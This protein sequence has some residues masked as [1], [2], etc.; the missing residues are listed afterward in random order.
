M[1]SYRRINLCGDKGYAMKK[2]DRDALLENKIK[3]VVPARKNQKKRTTNWEKK[4]LKKRYNI[5]HVFQ[6]L[7]RYNRISVRRDRTINSYTSFIYLA[8]F[9]NFPK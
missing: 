3:M 5:E 9:I 1:K 8:L 7:K 6:S 2:I 4:I